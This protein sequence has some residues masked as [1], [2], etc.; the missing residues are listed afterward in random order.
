MRKPEA[1]GLKVQ[2]AWGPP[3]QQTKAQAKGIGT[4]GG[5]TSHPPPCGNR[6]I[7]QPQGAVWPAFPGWGSRLL[8]CEREKGHSWVSG[9]AALPEATHF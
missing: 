2:R 8:S 7:S 4:M 3:V 5:A 6:A 1:D 9:V